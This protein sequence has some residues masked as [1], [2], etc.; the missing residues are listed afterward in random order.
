MNQE[1]RDIP[2]DQVFPTKDNQRN[3]DVSTGDFQEFMESIKAGGVRVPIQVRAMEK[4][5]Y[6]IRAGERRWRASKEVGLKTIPA[7]I[8]SDIE[9]ETALDLT[10]IENKF[11]EDLKPMEE[12]AEIALLID[13][14]G[15]NAKAISQRIGKSEHWVRLRANI[16]RNLMP[17]WKKVFE[18]PDTKEGRKFTNWTVGHLTLIARL[19]ENIQQE[20]FNNLMDY[21]DTSKTSINDLDELIARLTNCLSKVKW[22]I[23]DETLLPAAGACSKCLKQ[24]GFQPVLWEDVAGQ[25]KAG[26]MCLDRYCWM[27]KSSAYIERKAKELRDKHPDMIYITTDY[28]PDKEAEHLHDKFGKYLNLYEYENAGN[29]ESK[30]SI[31]AMVLHGKGVGTLRFIK[32]KNDNAAANSRAVS[33][34]SLKERRAALDAKR[35]SQVL[36]DLRVKVNETHV[37][38]I[39]YAD[40]TTALIV[41]AAYYGIQPDWDVQRNLKY[42]DVEKT[43]KSGSDR[44]LEIIWERL[45]KTLSKIIIYN[46]PITQTPQHLIDEAKWVSEIIQANLKRMFEDVSKRKGFTEPASWKSLNAD[47]TPK[48][49]KGAKSAKSKKV[50]KEIDPPID[51][52][53]ESD[54]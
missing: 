3:I 36:I 20:L 5:R 1:I 17:Q 14:F 6:E 43:I 33:S 28:P 25:K 29:K 54:E 12:A 22:N 18:N 51:T 41:L 15:D 23:D 13:R 39:I 16:H 19:P 45:Q 49:A 35:W 48:S 52:E 11:R 40:K 31:P 26:A 38:D 47:G 42:S 2:I 34:K 7:I 21:W 4:G 27:E 9:D 46:G 50:K 44:A 37:K 10:Y 24:T 32:L 53:P 8:Y 30:G